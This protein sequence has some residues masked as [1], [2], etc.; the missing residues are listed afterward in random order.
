MNKWNFESCKNEAL[1]HTTKSDFSLNSGGAYNASRKNKWF[2]EITKHMIIYNKPNNYWTF[3]AC[4]NE[5]LKYIT[6]IEFRNQSSSAYQTAKRK[7]FLNEIC[8]HMIPLGNQ[9]KKLIYSYEFSDNYVYVG[10]TYNIIKRNWEHLTDIKSPVYKH[11]LKT[12]I[13][14]IHKILINEFVDV[15]EAKT[16]ENY[17]YEK[18]KSN[19]WKMLNKA[20]T[21]ALGGNKIY[22]TFEKCKEEALKYNTKYKFVKNSGSA[23]NSALKN[24]WLDIITTHMIKTQKPTGY[25]NIERCH[26]E[27][28]KYQRKCD[29]QK[30]SP[31]PYSAASKGGWIDIICGHMHR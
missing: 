11:I 14:P 9:H 3:D 8:A 19:G 24:N 17:W 23:Y 12:N 2:D 27:A 20:K 29:F 7:N 10:L 6:K 22:W 30:N 16:L 18:Y 1:K 13:I 5:A 28:V 15:N 25:W 31:S 26:D 4:K 21:G